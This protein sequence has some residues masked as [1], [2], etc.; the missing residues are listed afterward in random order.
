MAGRIS[1]LTALTAALAAKDD[2]VEVLD[3]S[4][5]S[6]APTGTNKRITLTDLNLPS[7][8]HAAP[9]IGRFTGIVG[10]SGFGAAALSSN[11]QNSITCQLYP[12]IFL[13]MTMSFDLIT[14]YVN[15]AATDVGGVFRLGVYNSDPSSLAPST[16]IIE[17]GS[18]SAETTG[19]KTIAINLTLTAGLYFT[20]I[21]FSAPTFAGTN[22]TVFFH[23][24]TFL[25]G[26]APN[27]NN[28]SIGGMTQQGGTL[29]DDARTNW[30]A[31]GGLGG[32]YPV[33]L[34]RRSA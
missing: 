28:W 29:P 19:F 20:A 5:T 21:A 10:A 34:L 18:V 27:D 14:V 25:Y 24:S 9:L 23:N 8:L 3:V 1:E 2:L 13:P 31:G 6:M 4:D 26:G 7:G 33:V 15:V 22:P 12:P 17:A 11:T 16:K 32:S 30:V